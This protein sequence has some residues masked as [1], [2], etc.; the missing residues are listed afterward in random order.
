MEKLDKCG[1]ECLDC[2]E[3]TC[4]FYDMPEPILSV[5]RD[6]LDGYLRGEI[7]LSEDI[8]IERMIREEHGEQ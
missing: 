8:C 1:G 4:F 2:A 7:N 5:Q 3:T 6:L